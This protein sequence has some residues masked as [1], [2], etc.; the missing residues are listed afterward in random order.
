MQLSLTAVLMWAAGFLGNLL[1]LVVLFLRRKAG[2]VPWFAAWVVFNLLYTLVLF[3][4]YRM[5]SRHLYIE[6]YWSGA[7]LDLLLQ[8]S[9]VL[10]IAA[11]VFTRH[12]K[13]LYGSRRAVLLAGTSAAF[14]ALLMGWAMTP[15]ASSR[16]E[17]LEARLD[18][19]S[20]VL[21]TVF[22]TSIMVL[23]HRLGMSWRTLVLR[24]GYGVA[25]WSLFSFFA[26]TLHAYWRTAGHFVL[27]ER[28]RI[29][30]Y[31]GAVAYWCIVF[32][33]PEQSQAV[34]TGKQKKDVEML[35]G[36]LK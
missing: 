29:F 20:T 26:D 24:E 25:F 35:I 3:S 36:G 21:I 34:L 2:V 7:F 10:E 18:L 32:W 33:I 9:L 17:G 31:L 11:I 28:L 23:S 8:I 1:L 22:F 27:L 4:A 16:L 19:A 13:W 14:A 15:A 6:L 30:A 5:G 12:G